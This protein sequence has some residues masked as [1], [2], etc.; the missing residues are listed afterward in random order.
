MANQKT[1][2]TTR[3]LAEYFRRNREDFYATLLP[4]IPDPR[5]RNAILDIV[6]SDYTDPDL[7][8]AIAELP[9]NSDHDEFI[10]A[11]GLRDLLKKSGYGRIFGRTVISI[12]DT[13][14]KAQTVEETGMLLFQNLAV[15]FP[16]LSPSFKREADFYR[17]ALTALIR[18]EDALRF[19]HFSPQ[20]R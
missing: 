10:S 1:T 14:Q 17:K 4:R 6:N 16:T 11:I 8:E 9:E 20:S 19:H 5:H 15:Q 12:F 13:L 18:L 7:I 2:R 3:E